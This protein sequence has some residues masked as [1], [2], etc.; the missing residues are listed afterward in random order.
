MHFAD[1]GE[2][3]RHAKEGS[4]KLDCCVA[5]SFHRCMHII[6]TIWIAASESASAHLKQDRSSRHNRELSVGTFTIRFALASSDA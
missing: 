2:T 6:L 3:D 4:T 1:I 5:T